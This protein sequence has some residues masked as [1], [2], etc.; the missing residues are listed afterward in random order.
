M[1]YEH[2][3]TEYE[4]KTYMD[5][6]IEPRAQN[7]SIHSSLNSTETGNDQPDLVPTKV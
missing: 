5:F 4:Q 7:L 6:Y 2:I 1:D 3:K